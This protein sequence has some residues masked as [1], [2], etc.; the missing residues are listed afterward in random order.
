MSGIAG[1]TGSMR[2]FCQVI[3]QVSGVEIP[4]GNLPGGLHLRL[5][6]CWVFVVDRGFFRLASPKHAIELLHLFHYAFRGMLV[7]HLDL[8]EPKAGKRNDAGKKMAPY[9]V[10]GPMKHRIDSDL[11]G[12]LAHPELLLDSISVKRCAHNLFRGPVVIVGHNYVLS[13]MDRSHEN[14]T[15]TGTMRLDTG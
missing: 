5:D 12:R 13:I 11:A 4:A 1:M 14:K 7:S 15:L 6:L 8:E 10:V 9:L 3:K 2:S